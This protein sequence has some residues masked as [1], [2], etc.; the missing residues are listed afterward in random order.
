MDSV[1]G[2]IG[3]YVQDG[4]SGYVGRI[5]DEVGA[6]T[7]AAVHGGFASLRGFYVSPHGHARLFHASRYGKAYVLKCLKADYLYVPLYRRALAKEFE[8]GLQLDHPCICRTLGME[9]VGELGPAVIME[10][11]DGCTLND[12]ISRGALTKALAVKFAG[13]LAG[14]LAYMHSKQI[15]HRDL[16]PANI[17]VTHNGLSMKLIDFSLADADTFAVLK[18]PAGSSG[19]IAP[20]QL[21]PGAKADVRADVYSLGMVMGDMAKATGDK[22]MAS[23]AAMCARRDVAARPRAADV[24]ALLRR[25]RMQLHLFVVLCIAAALA[26]A[27]VACALLYRNG[28]GLEAQAESSPADGNTAVDYTEWPAGR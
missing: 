4:T 1:N 22:R 9:D 12:M 16:K 6:Q 11:V 17:M 13:Q 26:C 3:E 23:V 10:R 24:P 18:Q 19:Y 28:N 8:I 20:E 25:N 7:D 14:A 15:M 2:N 21:L 5:D 27:C